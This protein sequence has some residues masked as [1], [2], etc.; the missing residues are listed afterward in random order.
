VNATWL[1]PISLVVC[2]STWERA[3]LLAFLFDNPLHDLFEVHF[4]HRRSEKC[5]MDYLRR[6]ANDGS[7]TATLLL[8]DNVSSIQLDAVLRK[9][10][11]TNA[12]TRATFVLRDKK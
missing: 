1:G 7:R 8:T 12:N 4:V 10:L 6:V 11:T 5:P 9:E 3:Q 2:G